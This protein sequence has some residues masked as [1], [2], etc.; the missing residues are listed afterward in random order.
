MSMEVNVDILD[1]LKLSLGL[2]LAILTN[3]FRQ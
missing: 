1:K 3:E 2:I